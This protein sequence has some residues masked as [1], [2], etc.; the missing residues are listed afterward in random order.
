M[1]AW[2]VARIDV[3]VNAFVLL[4]VFVIEYAMH[5]PFDPRR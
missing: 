2:R 4:C 3:A 1:T 5:Y